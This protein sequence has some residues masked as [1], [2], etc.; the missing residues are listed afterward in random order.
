[1]WKRKGV[2]EEEGGEELA[3]EQGYGKEC[4]GPESDQFIERSPRPGNEVE[5][6]NRS[7]WENAIYGQQC[8]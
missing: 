6:R 1:M 4:A 2:E 7:R 5:A 3:G 8:K